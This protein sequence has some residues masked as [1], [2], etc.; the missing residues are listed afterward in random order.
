MFLDWQSYTRLTTRNSRAQLL[1]GVGKHVGCALDARQ[2][3]RIGEVLRGGC[4]H[5]KL[6]LCRFRLECLVERGKGPRLRSSFEDTRQADCVTGI[7]HTGIKQTALLHNNVAAVISQL[8]QTREIY[9]A[10]R[11]WSETEH[12]PHPDVSIAV[13]SPEYLEEGKTLTS[14]TPE[15]RTY[16]ID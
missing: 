4:V 11:K 10:H 9:E 3:G 13:L 12:K 15:K 1:Q 14:S 16:Y 8:G 2:Q 6:L 5:R 7:V